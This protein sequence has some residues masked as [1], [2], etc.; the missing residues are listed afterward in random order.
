MTTHTEVDVV[1][2]GAGIAGLSA[3]YE[4]RE[5]NILVLDKRDRIGGRTLSGGAN[6]AWFNLGAQLITSPRLIDLCHELSIDLI[7][8]SRADFA[9]AVDGKF[10]K[11]NTAERLLSK[12]NMSWWE[13]IN[14]GIIVLRLQRQL[15]RLGRSTLEDRLQLDSQTLR[16]QMGSIS[17]KS[18]AVLDEFCENN[19][20]FATDQISGLIG[21]G[22]TLTTYID[23]KARKSVRGVRGGT[24][25]ICLEIEQRLKSGTIRV[26]SH[27]TSVQ[28]NTDHVIVSYTDDSGIEHTVRAKRA[29]CA[30]PANSVLEVFSDLPLERRDAF[31]RRTPYSRLLT[32]IWPVPDGIS[33]PWDG[34][35]IAPVVGSSPFGLFTNY[36]YLAKNIDPNVGG[37]ISTMANGRKAERLRD[38]DDNTVVRLFHDELVR[39][40]PSAAKHID[41]SKA[42]IQRWPV[43]LPPMLPGAYANRAQV[44]EP[45]GVTLFCGDYTADPGLSGAN[46]S[47]FHAGA[48]T[49]Q[50]L[51]SA[52]P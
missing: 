9:I 44:R 17:A 30:L 18:Q 24:Q 12:M 39:L 50:L 45:H 16:Q 26:G 41:P 31:R 48:K 32:I 40:F 25:R 21:L 8:V 33:A 43:G 49:L 47:G 46:N 7:D 15:K 37:F 27:I 42:V 4:L 28:N 19:T 38:L 11:T 14:F 22:Y 23:P 20:G 6:D 34:A 35:F 13:K 3:A 52:Q 1:I 29:I 51:K 5:Q 10:S 36:G 2:L